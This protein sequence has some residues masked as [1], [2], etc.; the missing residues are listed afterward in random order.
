MSLAIERLEPGLATLE[1]VEIADRLR[2]A[3]GD[4]FI[5]LDSSLF[6]PNLGRYSLIGLDP[7]RQ[8]SCCAGQCQ[9]D[10][11][12]VSGPVWAVLRSLLAEGA[13]EFLPQK[14]CRV[15]PAHRPAPGPAVTLVTWRM[16]WRC[17]RRRGIFPRQPPVISTGP[18][19]L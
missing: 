17:S 14:D 19:R 13:A 7:W 6:D 4:L 10:G 1:A 5:F 2:P 15:R 18:R 9:V 8:L 12:P 11:Q 16:I 3:D